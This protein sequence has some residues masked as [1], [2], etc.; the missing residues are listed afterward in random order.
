MGGAR[1]PASAFLAGLRGRCPQ[2]ARG[3][4]FSSYLKLAPR[5]TQCGAD[6]SM[7]DV[8][9]GATVF[10]ILIV[11]ALAVP[12]AFVAQVA[13]GWAPLASAALAVVAALLLSLLLLPAAKGVLFALQWAHRAGEGRPRDGQT[14]D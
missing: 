14:G 8:G 11:G 6:F 3:P 13:F 9:D 4:L 10:V 5:C 12:V 2:C 7:A 1:T